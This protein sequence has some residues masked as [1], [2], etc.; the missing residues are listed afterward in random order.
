MTTFI[1]TGK[2]GVHA[3]EIVLLIT[4]T[5]APTDPVNGGTTC[6]RGVTMTGTIIRNTG[7]ATRRAEE[8]TQNITRTNLINS[9]M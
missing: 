3:W 5:R 6:A 9:R 8:L 7:R 4:F 1:A 2:E